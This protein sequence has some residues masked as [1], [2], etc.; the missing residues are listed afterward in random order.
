MYCIRKHT[1]C[2]TRFLWGGVGGS[3]EGE[4]HSNEVLTF[5]VFKPNHWKIQKIIIYERLFP[6]D[7][8]CNLSSKKKGRLSLKAFFSFFVLWVSSLW[9]RDGF[10]AGKCPL[11]PEKI[12]HSGPCHR[13]SS[14]VCALC[15]VL[16]MNHSAS[17]LKG[18]SNEFG[19]L[20]A[21]TEWYFPLSLKDLMT[22]EVW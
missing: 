14:L 2:C 1:Y 15:G 7:E 3:L 21:K 4:Y 18:K 20:S 13:F 19:L 22:G 10:H 11:N 12:K 16:E 5:P 8:D 9:Q 17:Y 6:K